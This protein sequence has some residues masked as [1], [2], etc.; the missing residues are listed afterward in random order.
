MRSLVRRGRARTSDARSARTARS[1]APGTAS[2]MIECCAPSRI[3]SGAKV[4][5]EPLRQR[6]W[7]NVVGSRDGYGNDLDHLQLGIKLVIELRARRIIRALDLAGTRALVDPGLTVK[8]PH[9]DR[10][11]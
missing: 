6:K 5:A 8:C 2:R 3:G 10:P 4:C 11:P 9:I 7:R 1:S